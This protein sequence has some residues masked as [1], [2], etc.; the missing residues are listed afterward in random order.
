[1]LSATEIILCQQAVREAIEDE[2]LTISSPWIYR[3]HYF[4]RIY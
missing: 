1:M 4:R 3:R 2:G